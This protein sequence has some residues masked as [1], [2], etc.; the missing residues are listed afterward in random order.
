MNLR[1]NHEALPIYG[2]ARLFSIKIIES[3]KT[4][5]RGMGG[6]KI[7]NVLTSGQRCDTIIV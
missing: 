6:E 1:T 7:K 5:G 4:R 3:G 2:E